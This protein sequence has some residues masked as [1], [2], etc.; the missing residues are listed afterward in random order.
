MEA[1]Q[2]QSPS[3]LDR[4]AAAANG[5][6][7]AALAA[8]AAVQGWQVLGRYLLNDSPSWTEPLSALLLCTAMSCGA[9][10]MVHRQ[11]HFGFS[12]LRDAAPPKLRRV[13]VALVDVV[14]AAIGAALAVGATVLAIDGWSVSLAGVALPQG[15]P[16]V[17]LA[18]GGAL[19]GVFAG[20]GGIARWRGGASP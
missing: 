20:A 9:A 2:P 12:L 16:F 18:L 11:A 8:V 5:I 1:A 13:L 15:S 17:P 4:V 10:V 19:M 7:A 3:P 6:G 14:V